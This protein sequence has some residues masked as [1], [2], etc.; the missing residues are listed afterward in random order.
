MQTEKI[1]AGNTEDEVWQ[2]L[3]ADLREKEILQY[4]AVINQEGRKIVLDIDIDLGGG[5]E[6]GYATT[7]L[8]APITTDSFWFSIRRE[9]LLEEVGRL[10]GMQDVVMGYPEFDN[11]FLIKSNN[12]SK[13]K[14]VFSDPAVRNVLCYL[15]Q[16]VLEIKHVDNE[17]EEKQALLKFI[18][19]EG[20]TEP[21]LLRKIYHTFYLIVTALHAVADC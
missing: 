9:G 15:P 17:Q 2:Q 18:I 3:N 11:R 16:F 8:W 7:G 5:F 6:S 20:I 12:E 21:E 14:S 4:R 10:V 1:I 13:V 19:E